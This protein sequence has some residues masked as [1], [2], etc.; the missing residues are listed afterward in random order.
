MDIASNSVRHPY[1]RLVYGE[2]L[3]HIGYPIDVPEWG[4]CVI[5]RAVN[6]IRN[7][8]SGAYPITP[9]RADADIQGGLERL[10][11]L[12]FVSVV[13]VLDDFHRPNLENIC[14]AF[15]YVREFKSHYV[16]RRLAEPHLYS[17]NH[18]YE[19]KRALRTVRTGLLDL[20]FY[21]QDWNRLYDF[22]G[23][24]HKLGSLHRFSPD[25]ISKIATIDG[26]LGFGAWLDDELV[27]A[28][29]WVSHASVAQSHLAASNALGYKS[30]AAYALNAAA[31]E[32]FRDCELLN[33]GGGS[34]IADDHDDGLVRFKRGFTN[35]VARSFICGAVLN[36]VLYDELNQQFD[37]QGIDGFFP[38]YRCARSTS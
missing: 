35:D 1:G 36:H 26:F 7:D 19:I 6:T 10:R 2:T 12:G 22:L 30:K 9:M 23:T 8:C 11:K 28:H 18:R 5:A 33:F 27:S 32:H 37:T 38:S 20:S 15:S 14:S 29:I 17:K 31:L 25:H 21:E 24:R 34:G 3:G 16:N 4:C 13:L